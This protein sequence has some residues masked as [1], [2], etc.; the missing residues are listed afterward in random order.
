MGGREGRG[1]CWAGLLIPRG[2]HVSVQ[3][4]SSCWLFA[5]LPAAVSEEAGGCQKKKEKNLRKRFLRNP[6]QLLS[7]ELRS[8]LLLEL[9]TRHLAPMVYS[10]VSSKPACRE[11]EN[12]PREPESRQCLGELRSERSRGQSWAKGGRSSPAAPNKGRAG[13]GLGEGWATGMKTRFSQ[14]PQ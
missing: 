14:G 7:A 11:P 4:L 13:R 1:G 10:V 3:R 6:G 5:Q 2:F 9:R 8:L 12:I